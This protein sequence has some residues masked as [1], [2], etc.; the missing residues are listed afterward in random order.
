MVT[1]YEN[2]IIDDNI[3]LNDVEIKS[4]EDSSLEL[5]QSSLFGTK[6]I[7]DEDIFM[8]IY[9]SPVYYKQNSEFQ[10]EEYKK[11]LNIR[12]NPGHTIRAKNDEIEIVFWPIWKK[13]PETFKI[14][15]IGL[16]KKTDKYF[17]SKYIGDS[18]DNIYSEYTSPNPSLY[19]IRR[20]G[21]D[22]ILYQNED[23]FINFAL[24]DD[25][26]VHIYF[27]YRDRD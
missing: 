16:F 9:D 7:F 13:E 18:V 24:I 22:N 25:I 10:Y 12:E 15:W 17:L 8:N 1:L 26:V 4:T 3:N 23:K 27:G 19:G 11:E 5:A 21:K 6:D 2:E 20:Y 14:N